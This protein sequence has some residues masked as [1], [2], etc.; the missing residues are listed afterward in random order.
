MKRNPIFSLTRCC[1]VVISAASIFFLPRTA[2]AQSDN[3]IFARDNLV[4][5]CIVPFDSRKRGPEER[6]EMLTRLGIKKFAYDWRAEHIP[7]FDEEIEVLQ[8]YGIALTAWWFPSALNKDALTILD[9]LKRHNVKTQLWV[10]MNGGEIE[11]TPEE[12]RERIQQHVEILQP[13]V[14]AAAEIGCSIGLYN[15][16]HWFGE[17]DNQI[18]I[19]KALDAPNVGIVYNLHHGHRHVDQLPELLERMKPYLYAF[20]LNGMN[21]DGDQKGQKILP[22]AQGKLDLHLLKILRDSGYTGPVGIL[23]HTQDDAETTL[24]DNLVGLEWLVPQLDGGPPPGPKPVPQRASLRPKTEG[25]ASLSEAFG[26]ALAGGMVVA[27]NAAYRTPPLT[28]TCRVKLNSASG[29][30]ILVAND[31]KASG[32]HWEIFTQTGSG[33]LSVYMPG[34]TPDHLRTDQNLCDGKWHQVTFHYGAKEVALYIDGEEVARQA[35]KSNSKAT[36]PGGLAFGRLVGGGF[37]CDGPIDDVQMLRGIQPVSV[38]GNAPQKKNE[39]SIGLWSFDDLAPMAEAMSPTVEDPARRAALP[40]YQVIPA[41]DDA[42]LTP[43]NGY[44]KGAAY[45]TWQRSHGDNSNSRFSALDQINRDNVKDL[46]VAW[47]YRFGDGKGN[48]QCNPVIVGDT[49]YTPA[50]K[51]TLVALDARTGEEKW[52]FT[53]EGRPAHRG[54]TYWPGWGTHAPRLLVSAGRELWALDPNTGV[55]IA[56]FGNDGRIVTGEVR[57]ASAVFQNVIVL[58]GYAKDVFGYDVVSGERLWT[59]HTIPEPGEYGHDTWDGPE[60][61]ANCWGGMALDDQRGIAYIATGSPKPNFVGVY[62]KGSNL[63]A[64]CVIALD[65]LTGKRRW[66]FQEIRH[67]IWDLDIP[68]PPNLVTVMHN[69]TMVDAVAQVTKIGNTLLLDRLTGRSLFPFRMRRAPVSKLPGEQTWS[70]QPDVELPEP[71]SRQTFS[72]EDITTR[73]EEATAYVRQI[74][75]NAN[76]GWFEAFE[77]N[78]ATIFYG[79]HG[80]AEWTGAATDPRNGRLYVSANE[81]PW[82]ITLFQPVEIRRDPNLPPSRGQEVYVERCLECHGTNMEGNGMA[83][84]LHRLERRMKDDEVRALLQKGGN[85]MPIAEDLTPSDE[86]ALLDYI[87]LREPGIEIVQPEDTG[88]LNYLFNGYHKLL[89]QDGYP[90]CKAPWGTLNCINL[91]TGKIEWKVPLGYY[92]ELTLD[93]LYDTGAE[94]FGG[95]MVTAGGLVFCAGTPDN[96][97]RAFDADTGEEL[98]EHELPFGGYAPPATYEVDGKQYVVIAA[99]GGGKLGTEQGDAWVAFALPG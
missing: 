90:G 60:L 94:N 96:L 14:A 15:H 98:W 21:R 17:P 34:S 6:A 41:A 81:L 33:H 31:T 5:W 92:P 32:T 19:I 54:L 72:P 84:P 49:L 74:V 22:L 57:V 48:I 25:T 93:G 85:I 13:L 61:G 1:L 68:A 43:A 52:R 56:D 75:D 76:Y 44:P 78:K 30:N 64:N 29:F 7:T 38:A 67:D 2:S 95:A 47:A 11:C 16:G 4:A 66:H 40:E 39:H 20:N 82:V 62:H 73:S 26:H 86:D 79:L 99:T 36:V 89:D 3:E 70:Y 88:K 27:G 12:Q 9:A 8:R 87:Y 10:T 35:F 63:F 65:A 77:E 37:G 83:P 51:N 42:T 58:P 45:T 91:N 97:I 28:I 18:A 71:F 23:G 53:G 50:P 46:R 59:F 24:N 55:P 69:G 80:G